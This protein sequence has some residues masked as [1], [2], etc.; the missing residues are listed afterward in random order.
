MSKS[1]LVTGGTGA[2]GNAV[3]RSLL[4]DGNQVSVVYLVDEEWERLR[5]GL[6]TDADRVLGLKGDVLDPAFMNSAVAAAVAKHGGLQG[7]LHLV[8]GYAYGPLADTTLEAWRRMIQLNLE[9]AYVAARACL[10]AMKAEGGVMVFVAAQGALDAS[11]NQS[12]YNASKAGVVALA[13]TLARELRESGIRVNAIAPDIMDTPA[14]RRS[15]PRSDPSGWLTPQ[16]VAEVLSY[17]VSDAGSGV[18]GA[19]VNLSRS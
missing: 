7:L 4:H 8:G 1:I 14:N 10:D 11:P 2:L 18:D 12:A 19:V 3:V 6:D 5:L 16:Q 9:S 15:M 17:L 13:R